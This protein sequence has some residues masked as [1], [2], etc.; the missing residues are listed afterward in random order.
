MD[1]LSKILTPL[2]TCSLKWNS[3]ERTVPYDIFIHPK[4]INSYLVRAV[5][6]KYNS[7]IWLLMRKICRKPALYAFWVRR[8]HCCSKYDT[9]W[10]C[11]SKSL[12]ADIV[13]L[14]TWQWRLQEDGKQE[15]EGSRSQEHWWRYEVKRRSGV[16]H[17]CWIHTL[18]IPPCP[19]FL[20]WKA[21]ILPL[22]THD[23]PHLWLTRVGASRNATAMQPAPLFFWQVPAAHNFE[24]L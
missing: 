20:P 4:W 14:L 24:M 2:P 21:P 5:S 16:V 12:A 8:P 6:K 11:H 13:K 18:S 23:A 17:W 19:W 9:W 1:E 3:L 7:C 15:K 22:P 10:W